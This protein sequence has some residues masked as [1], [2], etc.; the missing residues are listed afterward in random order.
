MV[1]IKATAVTIPRAVV[2]FG[3]AMARIARMPTK[4]NPVPTLTSRG[5]LLAAELL[6]PFK[7]SAA[8][9]RLMASSSSGC[10]SSCVEPTESKIK[11]QLAR[12][13]VHAAPPSSPCR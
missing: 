6:A 11:R 12:M 8:H 1:G 7:A 9:A 4:R 2:R 5:Y 3:M 13:E 10:S